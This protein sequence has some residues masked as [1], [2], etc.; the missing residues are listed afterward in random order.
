LASKYNKLEGEFEAKLAVMQ[1]STSDGDEFQVLTTLLFSDFPQNRRNGEIWLTQLLISSLDGQNISPKVKEHTQNIFVSL[2][3]S[4][5]VQIRRIYLSIVNTLIHFLKSKYQ[6]DEMQQG[7]VTI[8]SVLNDNLIRL[9]K[10]HERNPI[11][12]MLMLDI[13]F[14][15][16][17]I[18]TSSS[19]E[20]SY[21][22]GDKFCTGYSLFLTGEISVSINLLKM[23]NINLLQHLFVQLSEDPSP[24]KVVLLQLIIELCKS[25]SLLECIGGVGFFQRI[26]ASRDPRTAYIAGKYIIE[27]LEDEDPEQY[28]SILSKLLIKAQEVDDEN[29]ISN[30]YLQIKIIL[31]MKTEEQNAKEK[32]Q[33]KA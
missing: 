20:S 33:D 2:A 15:L 16:L 26:L 28:H 13:I 3:E 12:L 17:V 25:K 4:Q 19:E 7:I 32:K 11:N 29:I 24:K 30:H 18:P 6:G 5:N 21:E 14:N 22:K 23:V 31:D 1:N 9:V 8:F 27:Q 10:L